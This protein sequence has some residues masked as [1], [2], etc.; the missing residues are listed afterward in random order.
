MQK[1]EIAKSTRNLISLSFML[2]LCANI[3]YNYTASVASEEQKNNFDANNSWTPYQTAN[4]GNV[5]FSWA[6][7]VFFVFALAEEWKLQNPIMLKLLANNKNGKV[8]T[9]FRW[10]T[11]K[12]KHHHG[13][14]T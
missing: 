4:N 10:C 7:T 8:K 5:L 6:S 14:A 12:Q 1:A 11:S 13:T 3:K 2:T 9:L